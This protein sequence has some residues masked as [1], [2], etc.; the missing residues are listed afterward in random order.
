MES[1]AA[2]GDCRCLVRDDVVGEVWCGGVGWRC[3]GVR[4]S[5][6]GCGVVGWNGWSGLV[7]C[8]FV[9]LS[10]PFPPVTALRDFFHVNANQVLS[11]PRAS[12]LTADKQRSLTEIF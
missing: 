4:C 10:P 5:V 3:G 1:E 12:P 11:A 6:V 7:W 2:C 8:P 9:P